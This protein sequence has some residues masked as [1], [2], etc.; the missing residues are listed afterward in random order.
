MKDWSRAVSIDD[1]GELP[2]GWLEGSVPT[3]PTYGGSPDPETLPLVP[4]LAK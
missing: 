3:M 4:V 1:L 2:A